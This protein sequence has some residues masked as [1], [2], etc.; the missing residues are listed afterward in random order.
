MYYAIY[1]SDGKLTKKNSDNWEDIKNLPNIVDLFKSD[2]LTL[3][4]FNDMFS[5]MRSIDGNR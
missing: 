1:I 5:L 4:D 3:K 2:S